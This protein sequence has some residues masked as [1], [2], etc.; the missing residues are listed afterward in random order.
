MDTIDYLMTQQTQSLNIQSD[1]NVC[2]AVDDIMEIFEKQGFTTIEI[3]DVELI[4]H[5]ITESI[6][7]HILST[8]TYA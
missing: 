7:K 2:M 4:R 3:P 5:L 1:L 8:K 6:Q